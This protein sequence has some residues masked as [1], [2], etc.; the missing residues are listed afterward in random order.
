M[1]RHLK[2]NFSSMLNFFITRLIYI[3]LFSL[4][5]AMFIIESNSYI[6]FILLFLYANQYVYRLL[7]STYLVTNAHTG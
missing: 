7:E 2:K 1:Y 6:F 3:Y 5:I 4:L